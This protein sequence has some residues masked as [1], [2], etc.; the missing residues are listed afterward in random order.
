[1]NPDPFSILLIAVLTA[2]FL[3]L[4]TRPIGQEPHTRYFEDADY[5][6]GTD[7]LLWRLLPDGRTVEV[8]FRQARWGKSSLKPAILLDP[9]EFREIPE[10]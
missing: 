4:V 8:R 3:Y 1:M 7:Y 5:P 6:P 10:P 2:I 9:A